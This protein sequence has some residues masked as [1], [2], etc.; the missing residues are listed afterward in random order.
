M[1]IPHQ[2]RTHPRA[3]HVRL[4][5]DPHHGVIVTVP[6]GFDHARVPGLLAERSDWLEKVQQRLELQRA[7][8]DTAVC[9]KRPERVE[10]SAFGET[11]AVHYRNT[12]GSRAR[13]IRH[14]G[15]LEIL[16]PEVPD[17]NLLDAL[18]SAALRRWLMAR[19]RDLLVPETRRLAEQHGFRIGRIT[20]RNQRSRWGSCSAQGNISLNAR[21]LLCS[22]PACRYVLLHELAHTEHLDHSPAFW[23]RVAELVPDHRDC[24]AELRSAWRR[25]PAWVQATDNNQNHG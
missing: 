23:Q 7:E 24:S 3:K 1:P 16:L 18:A 15:R 8:L 22:P 17:H 6:P 13:L 9:G 10:L 14:D 21:L 20:I 2:I 25:L 12:G 4:R 5:V 11:W 19:A